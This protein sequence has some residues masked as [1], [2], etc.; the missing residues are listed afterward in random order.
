MRGTPA[1]AENAGQTAA[2]SWPAAPC[3]PCWPCLKCAAPPPPPIPTRPS[4][5]AARHR[6]TAA[7]LQAAG[8]CHSCPCTHWGRGGCSRCCRGAG[9]QLR[10][11]HQRR[12]PPGA[13]VRDLH[14]H[15]CQH[16]VLAGEIYQQP[17]ACA[18]SV[19]SRCLPCACTTALSLYKVVLPLLRM[20]KH[21]HAKKVYKAQT[22]FAESKQQS[23]PSCGH[24]QPSGINS[25]AACAPSLQ[26]SSSSSY[27]GNTTSSSLRHM[28]AACTHTKSTTTACPRCGHVPCC[29]PA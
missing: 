25:D 10:Q 8:S 5:C 1:A 7:P 14:C 27:G 16:L 29:E 13:S 3:P 24:A 20:S 12:G 9:A 4:L 28:R 6:H 23:P 11:Q 2:R 15:S 18:P 22:G 21:R 19:A 17:P 26:G